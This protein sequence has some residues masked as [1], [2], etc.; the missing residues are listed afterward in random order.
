MKNSGIVDKTFG[1]DEILKTIEDENKSKIKPV[2]SDIDKSEPKV[3]LKPL[4]LY[5]TYELNEEGLRLYG[6]YKKQQYL[7]MLKWSFLGTVFGCL[8]AA[9]IDVSFKKMKYVTKDYL[10]AVVLVGSMGFFTYTGTQVSISV[11]RRKQNE[12]AQLYGKE[13]KERESE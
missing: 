10:K 1:A 12:L 13:I 2:F 6:K 11:F 9:I 8:F 7:N 3:D 5:K 4:K